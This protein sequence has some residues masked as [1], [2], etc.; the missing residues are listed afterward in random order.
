MSPYISATNLTYL[1]HA[2]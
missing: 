1:E 2:I